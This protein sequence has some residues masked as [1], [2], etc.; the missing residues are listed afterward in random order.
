VSDSGAA[1]EKCF[2]FWKIFQCFDANGECMPP[3]H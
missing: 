1:T 3:N 2:C